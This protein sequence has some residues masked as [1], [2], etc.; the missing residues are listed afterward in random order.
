MPASK[1]PCPETCPQAWQRAKVPAPSKE[2]LTPILVE[3]PR[4]LVAHDFR[5]VAEVHVMAAQSPQRARHA[6]SQASGRPQR[7]DGAGQPAGLGGHVGV[8]QQA[9]VRS[10]HPCSWA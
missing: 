2:V 1:S 4:R 8:M 3:S 6:V 7:A 10:T 5:R 9:A